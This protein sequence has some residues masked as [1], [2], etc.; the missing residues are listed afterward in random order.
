MTAISVHSATS[1]RPVGTRR[2]G[3][4]GPLPVALRISLTR[5]FT[6]MVGNT[7]EILPDKRSLVF[8]RGSDPLKVLVSA[9][10]KM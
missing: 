4:S 7:Q 6:S 9:K 1:A 2:R 5:C 10:G 8:L 3:D